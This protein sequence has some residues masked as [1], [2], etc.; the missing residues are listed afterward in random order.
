MVGLHFVAELWK[1]CFY[2]KHPVDLDMADFIVF[3]YLIGSRSHFKVWYRRMIVRKRKMKIQLT[4]L[5]V[6]VFLEV[7]P[8]PIKV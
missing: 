5:G 2:I 3:P 8:Q 6:L 1:V 7:G 4:G